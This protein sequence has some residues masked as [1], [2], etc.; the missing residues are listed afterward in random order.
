M[1][2]IFAAT[3]WEFIAAEALNSG[4][5]IAR[6]AWI[7][8]AVSFLTGVIITLEI[9]SAM[10]K[11]AY[12]NYERRLAIQLGVAETIVLTAL[13]VPYLLLA[14]WVL[15]FTWQ[16]AFK[17]AQILDTTDSG[18]FVGNL[19][20]TWFWFILCS[21]VSIPLAWALR[22]AMPQ[23]RENY[24]NAFRLLGAKRVFIGLLLMT[25]LRL[26]LPRKE[27]FQQSPVISWMPWLALGVILYLMIPLPVFKWVIP[28]MLV[29]L[30]VTIGLDMIAPPTW[31]FLGTSQFSSFAAFSTLRDSW[32]QHGLTLL[33]RAGSEGADFYF[34]Q[35]QSRRVNAMFPLNPTAPRVWCLR[36]RPEMWESSVLLLMDYVLVVVV[37]VRGESQIVRQEIDW[38]AKPERIGKTWFLVADDGYGAVLDHPLFCAETRDSRVNIVH[39]SRLA[40]ERML[41]SV[42]W[43]G[44]GIR[45]PKDGKVERMAPN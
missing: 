5:V 25:V 37:D 13:M 8:L 18:W 34:V 21:F 16:F 26:R 42:E 12:Q 1:F 19:W 11:H 20:P 35:M 15:G 32:R 30:S 7:L 9:W 31:L 2:S 10:L 45:L 6:G 36:T 38:L 14:K 40:T 24:A 27:L 4:L 3:V 39:H 44:A 23:V 17:W 33:D 28:I 29:C 41:C 22:A 43:S